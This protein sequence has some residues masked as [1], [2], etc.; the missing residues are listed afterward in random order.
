MLLFIF[1]RLYSLSPLVRASSGRE[2]GEAPTA[3]CARTVT[4][5][6]APHA[7]PRSHSALSPPATRADRAAPLAE[8]PRDHHTV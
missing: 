3:L 6:S 8:L 5:Y 4:R 7:S 2:C 1:Q